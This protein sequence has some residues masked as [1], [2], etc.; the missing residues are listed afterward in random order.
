MNI[1]TKM[2]KWLVAL[3]AGMIGASTAGAA[4][5]LGTPVDGTIVSGVGVISGYHCTSKN[6]DVYIDGVSI[7]KAG[8]G[9]TLGGTLD[10]CG[11]TDTGYALLYNFNNLTNGQHTF[12]VYAD[13]VLFDTH[14]VTT[15]QSGGMPWLSG[16]SAGYTLP[17]FP[18]VGQTATVHWVQSYQNFL[19]TSI[20]GTP[21]QTPTVDLS[22]LVGSDSFVY[23]QSTA[24]GSGCA[25][26]GISTGSSIE[27]LMASATANGSQLIFNLWGGGSY[28]TFTLNYQSGDASSG[29]NFSGTFHETPSGLSGTATALSLKNDGTYSTDYSGFISGTA[30]NCTIGA[31][32]S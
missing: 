9:T 10:V 31:S 5:V 18:E 22:S 8:A 30:S 20:S 16:K 11:H 2:L 14:T 26:L 25:G 3:T 24:S 17:N 28:Y 32:M 7:G 23:T 6:I 4:G 19:I 21:T 12:T 1:K 15:F 27:G 29:F 13:G